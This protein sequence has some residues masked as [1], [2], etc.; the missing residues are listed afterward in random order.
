MISRP[1]KAY[2]T[3]IKKGEWSKLP[4]GIFE[5]FC[6]IPD[7]ILG[8]QFVAGTYYAVGGA[9]IFGSKTGLLGPLWIGG[10]IS[11]LMGGGMLAAKHVLKICPAS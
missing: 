3:E 2:A 1:Y 11:M 4:Q 6:T 9:N 8:L 10:V 7:W 5:S